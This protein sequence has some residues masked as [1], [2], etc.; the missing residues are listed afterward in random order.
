MTIRPLTI[1]DASIYQTLRLKALK[2]NPE[3]YLAT[4]ETEQNKS[5]EAFAWEIRYATSS[6]ING[7]YGFLENQ[8]IGYT[9]LEQLSLPKQQHTAYLFNLYVDPDYRGQGYAS[10]LFDY[11]SKLAKEKAQVER[12][13]ITCNR[14]NTAAQKLYQ[15]LGFTQY[16]VKEKSVKWQG[17]YDDEVEMVKKL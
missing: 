17:E 14:K 15:K 6:P 9:Q 7:Y 12:I 4:W 16:G 3:S 1:T 5:T 2:T 10:K 11:L 8:L 13:F